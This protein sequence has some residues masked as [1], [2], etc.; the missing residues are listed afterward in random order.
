VN[1]FG[2]FHYPNF[3]IFFISRWLW[4]RW[5]KIEWLDKHVAKEHSRLLQKNNGYDHYKQSAFRQLSKTS[6]SSRWWLCI[7]C[8]IYMNCVLNFHLYC[9]LFMDTIYIYLKY[10]DK[11]KLLKCSLTTWS[12]SKTWLLPKLIHI[13]E[14]RAMN[15]TS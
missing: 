3:S 5:Q 1:G 10:G 12:S 9:L 14:T 6:H 7:I 13:M 15:P 11:L 8:F 4:H 2:H